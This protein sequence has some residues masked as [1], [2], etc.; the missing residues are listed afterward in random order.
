MDKAQQTIT[1][2][3]PSDKSYGDDAFTVSASSTSGLSVTFSA[4][5]PCSVTGGT[6]TITGAGACVITASQG[7]DHNW[8]AAQDVP[9][10]IQVARANQT[11]SFGALPD[12][13]YGSSGYMLTASA[14]SNLPVSF[15]VGAGDPCALEDDGATLTISGAGIC[16]VTA[17]QSGDANYDPASL[18]HDFSISQA[19]QSITFGPLSTRTYGAADFDVDDP[20]RRACPSRSVSTSTTTA[21]SRKDGSHH[22]RR[23]VHGDGIAGRKRQLRGRP[24][25]IADVCHQSG[26]S[27]D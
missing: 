5:G 23:D 27:V 11:I 1:F 2:V 4:S 7:G 9:Q 10:T 22:W 26:R 24:A 25:G 3:A 13:T 21:R 14:S 8:S 6:V 16:H 17:T 12:L 20:R 18:E 19:S 15:A